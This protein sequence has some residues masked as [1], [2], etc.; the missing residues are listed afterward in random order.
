M[1]ELGIAMRSVKSITG[2]VVDVHIDTIFDV[3]FGLTRRRLS[4]S[5][6]SDC[7]AVASAPRGPQSAVTAPEVGG[8]RHD[9]RP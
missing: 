6:E 1:D 2:P 5:E 9:I 7:V 3:I 4:S 8:T